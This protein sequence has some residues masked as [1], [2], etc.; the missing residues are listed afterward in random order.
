MTNEELC[1]EVAFRVF[2]WDGC[3]DTPWGKVCDP[4]V[5]P[6]VQFSE[7]CAV[8]VIRMMT[9]KGY[10]FDLHVNSEGVYEAVF[11]ENNG[12]GVGWCIVSSSFI[13]AVL[14]AACFILGGDEA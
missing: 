5:R 7:E 11:T 13:R 6:P 8:A 1:R 4:G 9:S 3:E 2:D 12:G 10:A 14:G